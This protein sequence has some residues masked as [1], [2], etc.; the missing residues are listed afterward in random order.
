MSKEQLFSKSEILLSTTDLDSRI[1]YAN[2]NFCDIAGYSLDEMLAQPHNM[3]RHK[4]MPKAAFADLWSYIQS[5]KSWMGPVKNRCKNGDYYWVN[6]FVTPIKD[7]NGQVYEYQSVRTVL[8]PEVKERAGELYKNLNAGNTP[9]Q[10]KFETDMT[11]WVFLLMLLMNVLSIANLFMTS[12]SLWLPVMFMVTSFIGT[13]IFSFWRTKYKKVMAEAKDVFDNPLMSYIYSGNNDALGSVSLALKMREA[14]LKAVVGRVLDD[15]E[16]L[17]ETAKEAAERGGD[18]ANILSEQKTET[19]QVATAINQ[20]FAT[21]KEISQVVTQAADRANE[22]L[23]ISES[24]KDTVNVTIRAIEQLSAQLSEVEEAFGRLIKGSQAISTVLE[25]I[26]SIADQ[27]NLLAL[28]AAIE[29]ARAGEQGRGFAVVAEEVR[30]LAQRTQTSTE[31]VGRILEQFQQES[32]LA[33]DS[34]AKG[35]KL[36]NDCVEHVNAAGISLSEI[37]SEVSEL[38]NIN[39]QIAA[40]VEEQSVVSEQVSKNIVSISEM[41][42]NSEDNGKESAQLSEQL[43]ERLAQQYSLITQ[44]IR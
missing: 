34:V 33:T 35:N 17:N 18:V 16:L 38:A 3:V 19:D 28:N 42:S 25:E 13:G 29:A 22:G 7:A 26:S 21:V 23:N 8:E 36:S 27:T 9:W 6:A 39:T 37:A 41:S 10:L 31:E 12:G 2:K 44:F 40:A 14:E 43:L 32:D 15:S 30:A 4:D 1:K 20:M 24:G 5:G 11:L